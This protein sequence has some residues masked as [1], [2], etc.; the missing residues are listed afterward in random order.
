LLSC[1]IRRVENLKSDR[2]IVFV[3]NRCKQL[4]E[5]KNLT[6]LDVVN[7]TGIGIGRIEMGNMD[8]TISTVQ[9][10]ADYFEISVSDFFSDP[11]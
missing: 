4:R 1:H 8:I 3:A 10:L 6:Q 11:K 2:I 9:K 5:S 7:D